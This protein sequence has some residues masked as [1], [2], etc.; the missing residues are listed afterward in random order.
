MN[1]E[2]AVIAPG[3]TFLFA[4]I[5]YGICVDGFKEKKKAIVAIMYI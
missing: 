4:Q 3:G 5:M 1:P 2:K